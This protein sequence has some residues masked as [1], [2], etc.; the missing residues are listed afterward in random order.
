MGRIIEGLVGEE[1]A[2][3]VG[4]YE[5][6][7]QEV[8]RLFLCHYLEKL[9]GR[10]EEPPPTSPSH[11]D[12]V[13]SMEVLTRRF[14]EQSLPLRTV[15]TLSL[16]PSPLSSAVIE[17]ETATETDVLAPS[18]SPSPSQL[19]PVGGSAGSDLQTHEL[20][21]LTN[22]INSLLT[23]SRLVEIAE[24]LTEACAVGRTEGAPA[25]STGETLFREA[26]ALYVLRVLLGLPTARL[27][28]VSWRQ[29]A[30]WGAWR[31]LSFQ[32]LQG[33]VQRVSAE[34]EGVAHSEIPLLDGDK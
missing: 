13:V 1:A 18:P 15:P 14:L 16:L 27:S 26:M 2:G 12:S 17:H 29:T 31:R 4:D 8:V 6:E 33:L 21:S 10:T 24:E 23:D 19:E 3:N 20:S 28:A 9:A 30:C 25:Q 22:D 7:Q 34:Y 32:Q 11:S 5:D